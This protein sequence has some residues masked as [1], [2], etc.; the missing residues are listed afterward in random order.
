ELQRDGQ[1][2]AAPLGGRAEEVHARARLRLADRVGRVAG[3][4]GD[5]VVGDRVGVHG[6]DVLAL[7]D[8][9]ARELPREEL[10]RVVARVVVVGPGR[11]GGAGVVDVDGQEVEQVAVRL[12]ARVAAQP[13]GADAARVD[14][15]VR[16][17][18][19]LEVRARV[20][21]VL[22]LPEVR[23]PDGRVRVA[24]WVALGAGVAVR[25]V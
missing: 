16:D 9:R 18:H 25:V 20:E 17:L 21:R 22:R 19:D 10:P 15:V 2:V 8:A 5:R 12:R 7:E 13:A 6:R 4:I 23:V 11:V 14:R 24:A 3:R 1:L